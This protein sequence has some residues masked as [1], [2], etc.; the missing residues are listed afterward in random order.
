MKRLYCLLAAFWVATPA[1][2]ETA[3]LHLDAATQVRLQIRTAPIVTA[4]S[5]G[6][7]SAYATVLDAG[8][9]LSLISDIDTAHA[10]LNASQAEAART[11]GLAQDATVAVKTAE[12]ARAQ[13]QMDQV[14]LRQLHQQLALEWGPYFS[15]MP[16]A[17]LHQLGADIAMARTALVR[18]DTPA[19][20][21]LSGSRAAT[22]TLNDQSLEA[23]ILGVA[24]TADV[25]LQSSGLIASV[26]GDGAAYLS[27]GLSLKAQLYSGGGTDGVL[28]PNAAL[29]RQNGQVFAYIKTSP[30]VFERRPL[31]LARPTTEGMIVAGGF[32]RGEAVVVQGASALVTAETPSGGED[33]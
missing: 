6:A 32:K 28:I 21:G 30:V 13:A 11:Q 12:A 2:T 19:G 18:L 27:R 23:R 22:L 5:K 3:R 25:R 16:D 24:R 15:Q 10:A 29:L 8:P 1:V 20:K 7:V 14:K 4:H 31:V 33:D 26:S 9:L 17:G